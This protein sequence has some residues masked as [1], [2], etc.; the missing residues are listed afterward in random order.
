[1]KITIRGAHDEVVDY[2]VRGAVNMPARKGKRP[3]ILFRSAENPTEQTCIVLLDHHKASNK[4]P[5]HVIR[6]LRTAVRMALKRP[7]RV[8]F[9]WVEK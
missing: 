8:A 1:M 2:M 9:G 4:T 6:H 7:S 5:D 3:A